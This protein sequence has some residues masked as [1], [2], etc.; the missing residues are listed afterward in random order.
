MK[1]TKDTTCWRLKGATDYQEQSLQHEELSAESISRI[2]D[3]QGNKEDCKRRRDNTTV[4]Q[5]EADFDD[6]M[7]S[8]AQQLVQNFLPQD[9]RP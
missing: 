5:L 9:S 3:T 8:L 4:E 2:E 6:K 1:S 7:A